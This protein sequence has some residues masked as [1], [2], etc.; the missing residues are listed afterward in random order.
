MLALA[1][2]LALAQTDLTPRPLPELAPPPPAPMPSMSLQVTQQPLTR[3]SRRS[4]VTLGLALLGSGYAATIATATAS[5]LTSTGSGGSDLRAMG[6]F[7]SAIPIA[8]PALAMLTDVF[9]RDSWVEARLLLHV[10][11]LVAQVSGTII[12]LRRPAVERRA[13]EFNGLGVA[14]TSGGAAVSLGGT[15]DFPH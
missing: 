7:A 3:P 5:W 10:A 9:V 2:T 11:S 15:F 6:A 14:P 4:N 12:A 1:L 8:G 13:V